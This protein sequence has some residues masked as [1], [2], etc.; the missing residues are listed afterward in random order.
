MGTKELSGSD[1][2]C[3]IYDGDVSTSINIYQHLY[4]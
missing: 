4:I 1:G 2:C 3:Y